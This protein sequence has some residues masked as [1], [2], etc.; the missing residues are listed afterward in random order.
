MGYAGL[1]YDEKSLL[2]NPSP[3]ILTP[4]AKSIRLRNILVRGSYPFDYTLDQNSVHFICSITYENMLCITDNS[5][6]QWIITTI[7]LTLDFQDIYLPL[8][9]D[10]CN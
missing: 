1:R 2:F 9:V 6:T 4:A 3:G 8:R 10:L 5:K 7:E